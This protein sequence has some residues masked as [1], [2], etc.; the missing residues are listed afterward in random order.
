M[1]T[2]SG[3][4]YANRMSRTIQIRNVPD[5]IYRV[6]ARRAKQEG[7]SVAE[8]VRRIVLEDAKQPTM[9]EVLA[10]LKK[11]QPVKLTVSAAEIIAKYGKSV[12][13]ILPACLTKITLLR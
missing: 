1:N 12:N 5:R 6:L 4:R 13:S 10:R 2:V 8:Y 11:R 7:I 9:K 3:S